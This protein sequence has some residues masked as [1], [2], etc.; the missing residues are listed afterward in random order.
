MIQLE[1]DQGS[2]GFMVASTTDA[3]GDLVTGFVWPVSERWLQPGTVQIVAQSSSESSR[4]QVAFQ[5]GRSGEEAPTAT[6]IV[7]TTATISP[8][9]T[10]T[11]T[12]TAT[13]TS[14][15]PLSPIVASDLTIPYLETPPEIDGDLAEW[16]N[17][18]GYLTP[19]IVEQLPEWDGSMDIEAVWRLGWNEDALYFGV[20]VID[21]RLVQ[22]NIPQFAYFG[23]SLEIELDTERQADLGPTVSRDD[24]QFLISPGNFQNLPAAVYRFQG[25]DEGRLTDAPGTTA[26]VAVQQTDTGYALEFAIPWRDVN[27]SPQSGLTLGAT[28]STND[29]DIPGSQRQQFLLLSN[30]A[31]RQWST[32]S[33]W[34][35]LTLQ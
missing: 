15:S 4:A 27:V 17:I 29:N 19:F 9:I 1:D 7:T 11:A 33:S 10:A 3:Q 13:A 25:T 18:Q 21:D 24:Y 31:G 5:V 6:P 22:E 16:S 32:P 14:T 2:S 12:P 30:I 28:L 35:T 20:N 34:G 8:T 26:G 23:D